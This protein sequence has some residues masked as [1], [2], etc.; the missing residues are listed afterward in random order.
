MPG[1]YPI[2]D[3]VTDFCEILSLRLIP[4]VIPLPGWNDGAPPSLVGRSNLYWCRSFCC[5]S[6]SCLVYL[7]TGW[8][9]IPAPGC[10]VPPASLSSW[11]VPE[12]PVA[13]GAA[14]VMG[15]PEIDFAS[16]VAFDTASI[17]GLSLTVFKGLSERTDRFAKLDTKLFPARFKDG[18]LASDGAAWLRAGL[19]KALALEGPPDIPVDAAPPA[20]AAGLVGDLAARVDDIWNFDALEFYIGGFACGKDEKP[21]LP[22]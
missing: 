21:A 12:S 18:W 17:A 2:Y 14:T 11:L 6:I 1:V 5:C 22:E 7:E 16:S 13:I 20:I 8:K 3:S 9:L 15:C 4:I 19:A 10:W